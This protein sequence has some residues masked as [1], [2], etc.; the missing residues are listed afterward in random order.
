MFQVATRLA[1]VAGIAILDQILGLD[2]AKSSDVSESLYL[3]VAKVVGAFLCG[4]GFSWLCVSWRMSLFLGPILTPRRLVVQAA[5]ALAS[6]IG[7]VLPARG[8]RWAA[9][10]RIA[11]FV[12]RVVAV[13]AGH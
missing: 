1:G 2:C 4:I 13:V 9:N 3:G 6:R 8:F 10:G 7:S 11:A 12:V 5:S